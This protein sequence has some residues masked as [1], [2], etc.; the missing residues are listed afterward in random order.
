[1][2]STKADQAIAWLRSKTFILGLLRQIQTRLN[3]KSPPLTVIRPV[4]TRWTSRYL[5]YCRLLQLRTSIQAM[6]EQDDALCSSQII[7]GTGS[8]KVKATETITCLRD[9][10]FWIAIKRQVSH[11]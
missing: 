8:A 10:G 3:P 1:V 5:A 9:E 2:Y 11:S 6:L 4:L 7:T